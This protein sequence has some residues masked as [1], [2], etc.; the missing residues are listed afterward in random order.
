[1]DTSA[2]SRRD[3]VAAVLALLTRSGWLA[4]AS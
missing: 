2:V 4:P 3:A 1:V